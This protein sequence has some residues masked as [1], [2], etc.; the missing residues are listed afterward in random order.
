M[1]LYAYL[2]TISTIMSYDLL[3]YTLYAEL[4]P[5]CWVEDEVMCPDSNSSNGTPLDRSELSKY[6][7]LTTCY[8]H[9]P[10][11]T[12]NWVGTPYISF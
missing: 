2:L 8:V 1:H 12:L 6:L 7:G 5:G 11:A 4:S 3:M 10:L 9:P